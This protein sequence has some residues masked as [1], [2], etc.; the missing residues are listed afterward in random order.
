MARVCRAPGCEEAKLCRAHIVPAGFARTLSKPGGHNRAIRS[1]GSKP[2]KQ[3]HGA[4]DD[5]ILCRRCDGLLGRYDEY[6]VRFCKSLPM[7]RDAATGEIYRRAPF[8]GSLFA[9]AML[10]ILWRASLSDREPFEEI[11]LGPYQ[12]RAGAILFGGAPLVS[13][14][15]LE[16]VLYRYA[17]DKHDARK[18]VFM[19]LRIRSGALNAFTLGL[20]GF[21][22]WIKVDQRPIDPMLAPFVVNAAS[23][24]RAPIIRFEETAEYAYFQQAAHQDRRRGQRPPTQA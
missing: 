3:P 24:L 1:T 2:A 4:F 17:S 13:C 11:A 7:T 18:F 16:L 10:A 6:A 8:D 9:R 22:V 23:E 14:P 21:L 5:G 19:P 20:G 12:D 15:E